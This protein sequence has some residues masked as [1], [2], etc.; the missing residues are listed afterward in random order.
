MARQLHHWQAWRMPLTFS[1]KEGFITL[2]GLAWCLC[3][4]TFKM[5]FLWVPKLPDHRWVTSYRPGFHRQENQ[6]VVPASS[7]VVSPGCG[8][9]MGGVHMP[10]RCVLWFPKLFFLLNRQHTQ[11][12]NKAH[13]DGILKSKF[14]QNPSCSSNTML[15]LNFTKLMTWPSLYPLRVF[16]FL[17]SKWNVYTPNEHSHSERSLVDILGW[18]GWATT[19]TGPHHLI[20][21]QLGESSYR[22]WHRRAV[23]SLWDQVQEA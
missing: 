3:P 7:Q 16:G 21:P 22:T 5:V 1:T 13:R 4:G 12:E 6:K 2:Q 10:S 8:G 19:D 14:N 11:Q 20:L 9:H 18:Q 17:S 15:T 23:L